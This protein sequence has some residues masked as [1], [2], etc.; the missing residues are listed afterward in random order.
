MLRSPRGRLGHLLDFLLYLSHP[1]CV[2]FYRTHTVYRPSG[3]RPSDS[4]GRHYRP[5]CVIRHRGRH[6]RG[7]GEPR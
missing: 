1:S 6:T 5:G 4:S 3:V 7:R 2:R